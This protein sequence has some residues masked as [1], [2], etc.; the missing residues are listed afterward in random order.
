MV[1]GLVV[2]G[3]LGIGNVLALILGGVAIGLLAAV[4]NAFWT[5]YRSTAMTLAY[6]Q[7]AEKSP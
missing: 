4:L 2:D 1:I 7:L 6:R 5:S 3:T